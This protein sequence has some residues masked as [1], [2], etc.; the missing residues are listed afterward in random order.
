MRNTFDDFSTVKEGTN[1][2][3]DR[4]VE[5]VQ[6][7]TQR[8]ERVEKKINKHATVGQYQMT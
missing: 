6:T 1:D 2:L 3:E 7:E 4:W 5:T 8:E